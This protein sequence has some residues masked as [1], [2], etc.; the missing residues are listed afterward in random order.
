[1]STDLNLDDVFLDADAAFGGVPPEA[2][3]QR[4]SDMAKQQWELE[5][6]IAEAEAV[7]STLK[8]NHRRLS[9]EQIPELMDELAMSEFKLA[10]GVKVKVAPFYS[11]KITDDKAFEWLESTGHGDI[12]KGNV[13]MPYPKG[14]DKEKLR[15]IADAAKAAGLHADI[16]EEVHHS[17]LRAWLK[18]MIETGQQFPRELFNTYVGKRTKLTLK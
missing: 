15:M 18:E 1:M 7:L 4:L 6:R 11:G 8:E 9:E 10:N 13:Y 3:L 5:N 14:F 17:T 2:K 16:K 12:I